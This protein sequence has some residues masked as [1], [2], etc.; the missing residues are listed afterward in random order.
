MGLHYFNFPLALLT[1]A[2]FCVRMLWT[3][4]IFQL[5]SAVGLAILSIWDTADYSTAHNIG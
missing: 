4:I 1:R 3:S 5:I 2:H